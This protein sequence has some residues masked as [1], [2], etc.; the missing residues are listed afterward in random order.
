QPDETLALRALETRDEN[1]RAAMEWARQEGTPALFAELALRVGMARMRCGFHQEAVGPVQAG[2]EAIRPSLSGP[3]SGEEKGTRRRGRST[4]GPIYP[5]SEELYAELL[6]ERA[7]LHLDFAETEAA[8]QL[9]QE[10]LA[11]F[12][13]RAD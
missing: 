13:R 10:A 3:G 9:A 5:S 12:E 11:L 4:H 8:R 6:R 2:L 7:G 1:L